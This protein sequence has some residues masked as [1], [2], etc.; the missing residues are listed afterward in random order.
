MTCLLKDDYNI[1][2]FKIIQKWV[3]ELFIYETYLSTKHAHYTQKKT[4]HKQQQ[5]TTK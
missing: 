1:T 3:S 4:T 5:K 2:N